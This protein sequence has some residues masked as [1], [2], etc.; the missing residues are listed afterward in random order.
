MIWPATWVAAVAGFG[1]ASVPGALL[2]GVLGHL[3]DRRL[4]LGNW[5]QLLALL[6]Q[7]S[8][9]GHDELRFMLLGRLARCHGQVRPIH[10][11][12]AREEMQRL[13]LDGASRQLA[14]S[15][16]SRGKQADDD[17]QMALNRLRAHRAEAQSLLLSCWRMLEA[18]GGATAQERQLIARWAA[19]M[20]WSFDELEA[21]TIGMGAGRAGADSAYLSA[22]QLL[23]VSLDAEPAAIKRAYRRLLSQNHPD[24]QAGS[25]ATVEQV[26]LATENTRNLRSAYA[27]VRERHG[28]R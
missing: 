2:G 25:G 23:G 16:F 24:K 8:P 9:L 18:S 26:R 13:S 12:Q 5:S 4:R 7:P 22:L 15:A 21:L 19:W 14:E 17:L 3:L 28:F 27:L 11:A 10:I 1:L 20:G 6:G